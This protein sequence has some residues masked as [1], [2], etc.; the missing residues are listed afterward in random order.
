MK[1]RYMDAE[2]HEELQTGSGYKGKK[3]VEWLDEEGTE[4][5]EDLFTNMNNTID[6]LVGI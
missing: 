5:V 1:T 2:R 6:S 3:T 4:Q